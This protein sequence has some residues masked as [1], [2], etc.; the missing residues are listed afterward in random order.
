[1]ILQPVQTWQSSPSKSILQHP[2][3]LCLPEREHKL[4]P[5][6]VCHIGTIHEHHN[7]H[8]ALQQSIGSDSKLRH[9]YSGLRE[10]L[11]LGM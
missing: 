2:A 1:M 7:M 5:H 10:A 9:M 11:T 8:E 6:A 3:W 4:S